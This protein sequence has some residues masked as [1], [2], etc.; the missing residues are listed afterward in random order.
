MQTTIYCQKEKLD[1][2]TRSYTEKKLKKLENYRSIIGEIKITYMQEGSKK[3]NKLAEG[4]V[5]I[6]GKTLVAKSKPA[7]S[8]TAAMDLLIDTLTQQLTNS[9]ERH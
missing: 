9:K 3:N 7:E 8:Y 2:N 1:D 4:I 6:K 5:H